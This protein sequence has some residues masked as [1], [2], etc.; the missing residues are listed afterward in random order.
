MIKDYELDWTAILGDT[1]KEKYEGVWLKLH[2]ICKAQN[3]IHILTS[4][5]IAS[6]F[7]TA[8]TGFYPDSDES[9]KCQVKLVRSYDRYPTRLPGEPSLWKDTSITKPIMYIM[10]EDGI[11]TLTLTNYIV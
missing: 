6:I 2:A 3:V 9:Q 5:E 7:E 11:D 8:C 10:H 1:I 4:P